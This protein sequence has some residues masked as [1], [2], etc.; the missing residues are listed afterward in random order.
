MRRNLG[1]VVL[2]GVTIFSSC[3]RKEGGEAAKSASETS[4]A[5]QAASGPHAVVLL[6][7][8]SKVPGAIVASSQADMV[9]A[10]DDG[11]E[12]KIPLTQVKSVEYG[13]ASQA[14][15]VR[16]RQREAPQPPQAPRESTPSQQPAS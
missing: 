1:V 2:L 5:T 14:A 15:P 8:G 7:D 10:G 4:Q 6:K 9:V 3:A 16:Q 11:I 12:R 13:E